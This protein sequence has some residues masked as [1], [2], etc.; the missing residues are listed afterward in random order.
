MSEEGRKQPADRNKIETFHPIRMSKAADEVIAVLVDAIR[1]GAYEPGDPLP[2]ER[3]LAVQLEVSRPVVAQAMDALRRAGIVTSRRGVGGGWFVASFEKIPQVLGDLRGDTLTNVQTVL[4]MRRSLEMAVALLAVERAGDK[5]VERLEDFADQLEQSL[6]RPI[7]E[8]W[9]IDCRF[10]LALADISGNEMLARSMTDTLDDL[11]II[12]ATITYGHVPPENSPA[13][14]HRY[15]AAL[16][17]RDPL[18]VARA[19][20]DHLAN[21]E[22]VYLGQRLRF[23]PASLAIR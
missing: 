14:Q 10:H 3:E 11:T 21:L 20:D 18:L 15:M 2:R 16:K 8:I 17:T 1:G 7:Q 23:L 9:T 22:E 19:V 12:R 5:D 13:S 4:E 6:G